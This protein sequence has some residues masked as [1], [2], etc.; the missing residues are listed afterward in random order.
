MPSTK[1]T[2]LP[3]TEQLI[4]EADTWVKTIFPRLEEK[5]SREW[6]ETRLRQGLR[7]GVLTLTIEAVKE[8]DRGDEIA[9]AALRHVYAEMVGGAIP[10]RGPGHLQVWSYGQRAVLRAPHKRKRG[11]HHWTD[12]WMR[13]L[14]ICF[15]IGLA[16]AQFNLLPTRNRADRRADR[17]HRTH[18]NP[19]GTSVIVAALS[20]N[21][22]NL[23]ESSVQENIWYGL[24][25]ELARRAMAERALQSQPVQ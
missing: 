5:Y 8:A 12:N 22:I 2:V 15:L 20:R 11:R 3:E 1:L 17:K 18:R 9:D 6:L 21:G 24:P 19:S 4:T 13:D 25:G 16:C 23:D 10:E 7:E 14:E